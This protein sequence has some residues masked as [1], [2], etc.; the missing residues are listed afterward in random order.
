MNT[1]MNSDAHPVIMVQCP[2]WDQLVH[3]AVVIILYY[4]SI[5]LVLPGKST[6]IYNYGTLHENM[7]FLAK[8]FTKCCK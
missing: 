5:V 2:E 7:Y 8:V 6:G 1:D 4:F 3:H